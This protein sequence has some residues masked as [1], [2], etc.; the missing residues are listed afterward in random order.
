MKCETRTIHFLL[1]ISP[2]IIKEHKEK[3]DVGDSYHKLSPHASPQGEGNSDKVLST[4]IQSFERL[5]QCFIWFGELILSRRCVSSPW[6]TVP[7]SWVGRVEDGRVVAGPRRN[8]EVRRMIGSG[9]GRPT[10]KRCQRRSGAAPLPR[11][12]GAPHYRFRSLACPGKDG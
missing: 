2:T 7:P 9:A 8:D 3:P 12:S 5:T 4:G 6:V 10:W 11:P 1:A